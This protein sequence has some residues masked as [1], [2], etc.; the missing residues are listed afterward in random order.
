MPVVGRALPGA[1]AGAGATL[2]PPRSANQRRLAIQAIAGDV[3]GPATRD[4]QALRR[5]ATVS[6]GG[7]D[8][9]ARAAVLVVFQV[10]DERFQP[11]QSERKEEAKHDQ[12]QYRQQAADNHVVAERSSGPTPQTEIICK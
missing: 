2:R 6:D 8:Q 4:L 10:Q 7:L 3:G 5:D 11:A 1:G 12:E 9:F